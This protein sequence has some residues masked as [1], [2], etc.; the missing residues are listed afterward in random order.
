MR[1]MWAF[2]F[3]LA[4][5][6]DPT[7]A[8]TDMRRLESPGNAPPGDDTNGEGVWIST[9]V[10]DQDAYDAWVSHQGFSPCTCSAAC[11]IA[12]GSY[13]KHLALDENFLGDHY[14]PGSASALKTL[15]S[16]LLG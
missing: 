11:E 1:A 8:V 9:V 16:F 2:L 5:S 14:E 4:D 13:P 6:S 10:E 12:A 15:H 7:D 3:W